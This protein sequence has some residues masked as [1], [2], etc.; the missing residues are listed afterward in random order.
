MRRLA[1]FVEDSGFQ[2]LLIGYP[3]SE[4]T[5][6]ILATGIFD[7][8]PT[9]GRVHFVGHSM[10]GILAVRVTKMLPIAR[11]G[12]IVQIGAPNF[13][14]E[15]AERAAIFGKLIGPALSE[16]VPNDGHDDEG[17][18][19]G[20]IA[21]TAAIPAY[22]LITGIDGDNDGKVSVLS[23][24]GNTPEGKHVSFPVA[25]SIMMQDKRVISA[26]IEFLKTGTFSVAR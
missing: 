25:H 19:I 6:E 23:A 16:L 24:W 14:S 13:G 8:L 11:R 3:S 21:G 20:A 26:T 4:S 10:G 15:I 9:T 22:G 18:D 7:Q 12:R 1:K 2:T 5:L 17:L